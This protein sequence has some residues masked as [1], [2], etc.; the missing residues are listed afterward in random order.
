MSLVRIAPGG[1]SPD[2]AERFRELLVPLESRSRGRVTVE[3]LLD[4]HR[5]GACAIY[6]VVDGVDVPSVVAVRV[7]TYDCGER[8]FRI[9]H[10]AGRIEDAIRLM[11]ALESMARRAG[12][13]RMRI[14]GRSGW[15]RVFREQ[16]WEIVASV[17]E[18]ELR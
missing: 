7:V 5:T 10:A 18:K 16:G 3:K 6:A 13:R 17:M 2:L 14:E 9:D 8:V 11:P 12:C 1:V 15:A 4:D